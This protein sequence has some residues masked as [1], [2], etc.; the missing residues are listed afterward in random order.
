[1]TVRVSKPAFN[2]RD[3]LSE[4]DKPSGIKGNELMRS[5][6]AQ[7]ARNLIGAGR[8]NKFTNGAMRISQRGTSHSLDTD[9]HYSL[10]RIKHIVR[11]THDSTY[12]QSSDHPDGFSKSLKI[13]PNGTHTPTGS[14][15]AG[16]QSFIEGQDLQDLQFGT[17]NPKTFTVSFYAKSG[18]SNN[19]HQYTFQ[20]R[21]Y[22]T[23]GDTNIK[24]FPF[25]VTTTWQRFSFVFTGDG[26]GD[27]ADTSGAGFACLWNLD[28]GPDDITSQYT[29]WT[30]LNKFRCV[31]G[32]SH[33][34]NNTSNEFYLT[35]VQLEVGDEATEFEHL[36]YAEELALCQR[37]Y[38]QIDGTSDLTPFAFGR[39]NG[40]QTIEAAVP[41]TVPLR[42]S[43]T[44]TCSHNTAWGHANANTSTTAP[45]VGRWTK[46]GTVLHVTFGGHSGMTNARVVNVHCG[47]SSNFIMDAEL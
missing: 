23:N 44:L 42:A 38:Q 17:A 8:K 47:S 3:K 2:L 30:T 19:G 5:D 41:L 10:D 46:Y 1:M 15:N 25:V 37:Y 29:E 40:T 13:S 22:K 16:F 7:D 43:P 27:I 26:N 32:Q 35:G 18:S 12:T 31:T 45:T 36:S 20:I 6:T 28:A 4:L 39:A 34:Q 9:T 14:D 24:T 33:F 21:S 11:G